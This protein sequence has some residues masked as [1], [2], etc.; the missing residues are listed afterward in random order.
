MRTILDVDE[1][2]ASKLRELAAASGVSI[3][4]LLATYVP[5]LRPSN[6]NGQ[7]ADNAVSAFENWAEDFP[8]DVPPLSDEA[9]SRASIYCGR[10]H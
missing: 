8:R 1:K 2:T 9:V 6:E 7:D 3:D 10:C 4:Q 5:G